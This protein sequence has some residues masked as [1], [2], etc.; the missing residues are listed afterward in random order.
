MSR[1]RSLLYAALATLGLSTALIVAPSGAPAAVSSEQLALTQ[2][3]HLAVIDDI[4]MWDARS[5]HP[6]I[7]AVS[8]D[9]VAGTIQI[10]WAGPVPSEVRAMADAAA[11]RG[12]DITFVPQEASE[13]ELVELAHALAASMPADGAFAIGIGADSLSV[14]VPTPEAAEAAGTE[15]IALEG[16]VL[17]VI[18]ETERAAEQL[19]ASLTVEET[20]TVPSTTA[21]TELAQGQP[22][23]ASAALFTGRSN[24]S[25]EVSGGLRVQTQF[26]NGTFVGCTSG[27]TGFHG[28]QPVIITAAHC[29]DFRDDRAVRNAAG[30]RIGTSDLVA[31]LND[32]ARPYDLGAIALS[33]DTRTLPR[34]YTG[35]TSTVNITDTQ[36]SF[37]PAGYQLCSSGQVTGWKCNMTTGAAYVACYGTECM[38]VQEVTAS[39]GNAFC[40]GDSGGPVVSTPSSGG[41]IAVG[42]VSGLRGNNVTCSARGLIAP[43]SQLMATLPGLQLHT[44]SGTV[45]GD[46]P[47]AILDRINRERSAAGL[48]P[49]SQDGCLSSMAQ[50]W[51]ATMAATS[52]LG[53]AHNP[54]LNAQARGC[55]MA[56]WGDNVGRTSGSAVSPNGIMDAWMASPAHRANLLS[57]SFTHVGVGVERGANGFWYYVLDFGRR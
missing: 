56:G 49:L 47:I 54:N 25:T 15:P 50:G 9:P 22:V 38:N 26:A 37:P 31:E 28:H 52:A 57:T 23:D 51:S 53:S 45:A 11:T 36:L 27:F 42:V 17:D 21:A 2:E 41:A 34:I 35:E 6:R 8:G 33:Y 30:T 48:G 1:R 4:S 13:A 10:G 12:I 55:G 3:A 18:D 14:E 24:D 43:M 16:E 29:S 46:A 40:R 44:V 5:P 19:G 32:G 39:S 20:D 7:G